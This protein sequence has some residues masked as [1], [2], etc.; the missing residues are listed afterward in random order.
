MAQYHMISISVEE[1]AAINFAISVTCSLQSFTCWITMLIVL[2]LF[3]R[4]WIKKKYNVCSNLCNPNSGTNEFYIDTEK[5][6][7]LGW[8]S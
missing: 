2:S 7:E 8:T 3:D 6:P 5:I 4:I 1:P